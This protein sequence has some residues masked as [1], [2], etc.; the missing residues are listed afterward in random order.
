MRASGS[1]NQTRAK[2]PA[3]TDGHDSGDRPLEDHVGDKEDD[4]GHPDRE[5]DHPDD[6]EGIGDLKQ[7]LLVAV[8]EANPV[9]GAR[10]NQEDRAGEGAEQRDHERVAL[11]VGGLAEALRKRDGEQERE[12]HLDAGERDPQFVEEL[13]QLPVHPLFVRLLRHSGGE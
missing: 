13:D 2:S 4:R 1:T 7:R 10:C 8:A 5:E 12:Q 6:R 3:V 9:V 11:Q